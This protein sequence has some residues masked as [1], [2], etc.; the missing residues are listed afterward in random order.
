MYSDDDYHF[1]DIEKEN[2]DQ[3]YLTEIKKPY[4]YE[5]VHYEGHGTQTSHEKNIFSNDVKN[6]SFFFGEFTSCSGGDFTTKDYIAGNYLFEGKGLLLNA[7]TKIGM[8]AVGQ[9]N[10]NNYYLL[11]IGE[12]FFEVGGANFGDLTLR[13]RYFDKP[14]SHGFDDPII[15]VD[16][17]HINLTESSPFVKITIKNLGRSRL[18]FVVNPRCFTELG[19]MFPLGGLASLNTSPNHFFL[20]GNKEG[21]Y[22]VRWELTGV[23]NEAPKREGSCR[24]DLYILSNDPVN[25]YISIPLEVGGL[26]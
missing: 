15:E 25:P 5:I 6:T 14:S 2:S 10:S 16:K 20:E 7:F 23:G 1:I 22:E 12:P 9:V 8:G 18:K 13:M 24:G 19:M 26:Q 17:Q 3:L 11:S 21:T 4:E